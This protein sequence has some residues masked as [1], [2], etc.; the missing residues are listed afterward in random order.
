MYKVV[1]K[2]HEKKTAEQK[3]L[4][5][6]KEKKELG[7]L[8][9]KWSKLQK[10]AIHQIKQQETF[11]GKINKTQEYSAK[12]NTLAK[13]IAATKVKYTKA[14][15]AKLAKDIIQQKTKLDKTNIL[16]NYPN[17]I[18]ERYTTFKNNVGNGT[19]DHI[20]ACD[21]YIKEADSIIKW[22][23]AYEKKGMVKMPQL[24]QSILA[25]REKLV[26]QKNY[27]TSKQYLDDAYN[28]LNKAL[29]TR[30]PVKR[31]EA[32]IGRAQKLVRLKAGTYKYNNQPLS[33]KKIFD[34][35]NKT[36]E[37]QD[38]INKFDTI[39]LS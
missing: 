4:A 27:L 31:G 30:D 19:I 2:A 34:K 36:E 13:E 38:Y 37:Y 25:I 5:T 15:Y 9:N 29:T 20:L 22:Q 1:S 33:C 32:K 35:V 39:M 17:Y 14:E 3:K 26:N 7:N 23:Q 11:V 10:A 16:T 8:N 24:S 21:K 18:K 28:K 6:E 12:Y